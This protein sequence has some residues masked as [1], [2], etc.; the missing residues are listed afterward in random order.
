MSKGSDTRTFTYD[1]SGSVLGVLQQTGRTTYQHDQEGRLLS[2]AGPTGQ[3]STY[4][5]AGGLPEE[6][7]G[8]RR[9][10]QEHGSTLRHLVWDGSTY[11]A[12]YGGTQASVRYLA[13]GDELLGHFQSG[14]PHCYLPDGLGS[15][16]ALLDL[17]QQIT[18]TFDY[19][20]YGEERLRMG[21][22]WIPFRF[23]GI[24]GYYQDEA[25]RIYVRAR[26]LLPHWAR[27]SSLDPLII[28]SV[29]GESGYAYTR[30][31]PISLVDPSG[32]RGLVRTDFINCNPAQQ[33]A[34]GDAWNDL[35]KH[36]QA[37]DTR[38]YNVCHECYNRYPVD[39]YR[40]GCGR[41]PQFE[42]N[43]QCGKVKGRNVCATGCPRGGPRKIQLCAA[44]SDRSSG[45]DPIVVCQIGHELIHCCHVPH[46]HRGSPADIRCY[47]CFRE[48]FVDEL[49]QPWRRCQPYRG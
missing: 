26:T 25:N 46:T 41:P 21:T 38:C 20:P 7:E 42:C 29:S 45:C 31:N 30:G 32:L 28:T 17:Q 48:T 23:V 9:S 33:K 16:I 5:Y 14:T 43:V 13:L 22:A 49:D 34:I 2:V 44:L 19:R 11:L 18:D 1:R 3:Q 39:C 27:W 6:R 37:I 4:T 24:L 12:E 35:C 15:V 36:A 10:V 47:N 40:D 8:L